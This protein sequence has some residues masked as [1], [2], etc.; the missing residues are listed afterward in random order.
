MTLQEILFGTFI[1]PKAQGTR[2]NRTEWARC[3][4]RYEPPR[5]PV[6][7]ITAGAQRAL[8]VI[9]LNPGISPVE[10]ATHLNCHLSH[11]YKMRDSLLKQNRIEC[12]RSCS[13]TRK[14]RITTRMYVR[15]K[16]AC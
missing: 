12:V 4:K 8:D 16:N 2:R 5:Q 6:E 9:M 15:S 10:L 13:P 3:V 1:P 7:Q 14:G 11:A